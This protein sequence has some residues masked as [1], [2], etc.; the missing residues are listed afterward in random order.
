MS[1]AKPP[2]PPGTFATIQ[3]I[4]PDWQGGDRRSRG[5]L[6]HLLRRKGVSTG[7]MSLFCLNMVIGI[8]LI[9]TKGRVLSM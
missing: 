2:K 5:A 1:K 3:A 7:R 8:Y 6:L 4:V 9:S